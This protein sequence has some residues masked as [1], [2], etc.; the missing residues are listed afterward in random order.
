MPDKIRVVHYLNQ[1]FA[2]LGGEEKGSVG[3]GIKPGPVGPGRALLQAF[4]SEADVVATIYCGDNYFAE[5]EES[6]LE[7]LLAMIESSKAWL[8]I[9]GPA[10]ESGRYGVACGAI[11]A[12]AQKRFGISAVAAMAD[13]N[14]GASLY[15]RN[16]YIVDCGSSVMGMNAAVKRMAAL[17]LK[18]ACGTAIGKPQDEGYLPRGIKR[19]EFVEKPP[20]ERAVDMLL[21][22]LRGESV[23][24]EITPPQFARTRAAPPLRDLSSAVIALVTDG[25]LVLEGNPE[26]IEPGRPTRYTAIS[27]AARDKLDAESFDVVH[28]G[29]DTT[30]ANRDPNR[31][32]PLD[33][34]RHLE[35]EGI[36]GRV[37]EIVHSTG[38]A[39]AAVENATRIGAEIAGRL[40]AAGVQGVILT[41]T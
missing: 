12:A 22:K 7:A 10:F 5:H 37:H 14:P 11:C 39:H 29:Y 18:L 8:L 15:R 36:I 19:N 4:G 35:K 13:S 25:G 34:A 40:Q 33:A 6:A 30:M 41:S 32:V 31:I 2:Q 24:P 21:A 28:S 9:A 27:V 16:V 20:A 23:T 26:K 3:P 17:G 1:F 38:G